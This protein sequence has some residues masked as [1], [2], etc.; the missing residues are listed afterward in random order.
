MNMKYKKIIFEAERLIA[1]NDAYNLMASKINPYGDGQAAKRI[2]K[3]IS[4]LW[5]E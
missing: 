4:N 3:I 2:V 1:N 5:Q